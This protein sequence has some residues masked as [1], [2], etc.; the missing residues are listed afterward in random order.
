MDREDVLAAEAE[1]LKVTSQVD[2]L[3]SPKGEP[4][5]AS[6]SLLEESIRFDSCSNSSAAEGRS[7][8]GSSPPSL[9]PALWATDSDSSETLV[10]QNLKTCED[11]AL[12]LDGGGG[13]LP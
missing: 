4:G 10:L 11:L 12:W 5:G 2:C 6:A 7:V 3:S 13:S 8:G 9:R 1:R